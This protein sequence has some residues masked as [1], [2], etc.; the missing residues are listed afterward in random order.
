MAKGRLCKEWQNNGFV[1]FYLSLHFNKNAS[2]DKQKHHCLPIPS[3]KYGIKE[4]A[5]LLLFQE[6]EDTPMPDEYRNLFAKVH[7][8][9]CSSCNL[10][11]FHVLGKFIIIFLK[12]FLKII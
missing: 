8:K 6:I 4:I 10:S 7:C 9:D 1:E 12:Y 5:R 2:K 11:Q 3:L